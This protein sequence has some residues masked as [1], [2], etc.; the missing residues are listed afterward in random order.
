MENNPDKCGK[1]SIP[2]VEKN[3]YNNNTIYNNTNIILEK[4]NIKEKEKETSKSEEF[5]VPNNDVKNPITLIYD[6]LKKLGI[7]YPPKSDLK[8]SFILQ[9]DSSFKRVCNEQGY[10]KVIHSIFAYCKND[11]FWKTKIT[12]LESFYKYWQTIYSTLI[13]NN[14]A[15]KLQTEEKTEENDALIN[16]LLS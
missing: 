9:N 3:P 11:K 16:L 1:K 4:E 15:P 6:E 2:G 12:S 10:D 13:L 5:L 8:F 7:P 14:S